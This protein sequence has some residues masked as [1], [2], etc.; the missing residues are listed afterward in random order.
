M[1]CFY[2]RSDLD[3]IGSAA[4]LHYSIGSKTGASRTNY[5]GMGHSDIVKIS[6]RQNTLILDIYR[7]NKYTNIQI[8]VGEDVYILDFCFSD[9]N[10]IEMLNK[11]T[12]L[13]IIDHHKTTRD[14]LD[15][16]NINLANDFVF[17][18]PKESAILLTWKFFNINEKIPPVIKLL[19]DYDTWQLSDP[20]VKAFNLGLRRRVS[21]DPV[22][23]IWDKLFETDFVVIE[24]IL[25]DG[26]IIVEN[27]KYEN[28]RLCKNNAFDSEING[29]KAIC[30]NTTRYC[31]DVFD[32][33]W[34]ENKYDI[35]VGFRLLNNKLWS[36]SFYT[37]K[38]DIDCSEIAKFYGGGGHPQASGCMVENINF[39]KK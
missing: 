17:I 12:N 26:E 21:G 29:Y 25:K 11:Y 5:I 7:H 4:V 37:T 30:V 32:S 22:N 16:N 35:M 14:R 18:N 24:N 28:E 20:K 27:E 9:I 19:S 3:G 23:K 1:K 10:I 36:V 33:I 15:S 38:N 39:L 31:S 2:H 13:T 6:K 34:D 8:N